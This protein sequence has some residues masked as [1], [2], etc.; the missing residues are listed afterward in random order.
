[1]VLGEVALPPSPGCCG[2]P[3]GTWVSWVPPCT[4]CPMVRGSPWSEPCSP[5]A[6]VGLWL[7]CAW[8]LGGHLQGNHPQSTGMQGQSITHWPA[9]PHAMSQRAMMCQGQAAGRSPRAASASGGFYQKSLNLHIPDSPGSLSQDPGRS[10]MGGNGNVP[11]AT[12]MV[13]SSGSHSSRCTKGLHQLP[14]VKLLHLYLFPSF[15]G[16]QFTGPCKTSKYSIFNYS[17]HK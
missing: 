8:A 11:T 5:C 16:R 2:G 13:T 3:V 12:T 4:H 6:R 15:H 7:G 10:T 1:M 9:A 14:K 17:I